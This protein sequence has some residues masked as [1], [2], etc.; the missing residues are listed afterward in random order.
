MFVCLFGGG[1]GGGRVIMGGIR[2]IHGLN[3]FLVT[4]IILIS[5]NIILCGVK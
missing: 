5:L 2:N 3:L 1:T 4:H